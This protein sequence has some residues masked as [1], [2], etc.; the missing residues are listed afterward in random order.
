[1][2]MHKLSLI[3]ALALGSLVAGA[4]TC[5]AQ[6]STNAPTKG[7]RKGAGL[8]QRVDM[9]ATQLNLNDEQKTKVTALFE[10]DAKKMRELRNDT[11]LSRDEQREKFRAMR[12][13]SDQKL[14]AIL[15]P[16]QWEKWQ[17]RPRQGR[18]PGADAEKKSDTKK[19]E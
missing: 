2:K 4:L 8:H 10:E 12:K 1:M 14:K 15:T 6:T 9:M 13:E 17:Q 18:P 11:S 16:E 7:D 19:A 3:A 5:S